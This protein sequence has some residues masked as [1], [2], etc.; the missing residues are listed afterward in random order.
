MV[1]F[2][3]PNSTHGND[4]SPHSNDSKSSTPLVDSGHGYETFDGEQSEHASGNT[5]NSELRRVR[6]QIALFTKKIHAEKR[7]LEKMNEEIAEC[8]AKLLTRSTSHS[9]ERGASGNAESMQKQI[10]LLED[11]LNKNLVAFNTKVAATKGLRR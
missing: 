7:R 5:K 6:K 2:K 4:T 9:T 11:R 1:L 8:E 3:H 10:R